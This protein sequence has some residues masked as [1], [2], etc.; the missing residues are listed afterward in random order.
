MVLVIQVEG[1]EL[2]VVVVVVGV[3]GLASDN[4]IKVYMMLK[5]V[6]MYGFG[7]S[8][9]TVDDPHIAVVRVGGCS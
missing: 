6:M 8:D 2:V 5:Q 1:V 3:D 7:G 9:N 4:N